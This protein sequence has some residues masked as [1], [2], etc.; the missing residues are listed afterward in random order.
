MIINY[1]EALKKYG[2][3]YKLIKA[4]EN[5]EI[6]K[7]EKGYYSDTKYY[8]Q[9]EYITKKYP[10]A[11]FTFQS[12]YLYLGL[13]DYIPSEYYIATTRNSKSITLNNVKQTYESLKYFGLGK[14]SLS[15]NG[16]AINIYDKER[17]LIELVRRQNKIPFDYYKEII[18]IYRDII[19][20]LD[21][22][23]LMDYIEVFD[24]SES[25]LETLNREVF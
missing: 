8:S 10:K 25:I 19:D 3:K 18:T 17:M 14:T 6:Y 16:V 20:E 23:K 13:S 11:I 12:A 7:I 4:I 21:M 2:N 22:N 5:K 9:I 15:V 24:N 1:K